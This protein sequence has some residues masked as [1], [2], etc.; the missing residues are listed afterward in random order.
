[1]A[2]KVLIVEDEV[3]VA[4]HLKADLED[5]GFE[6]TALCISSEECF[7]AVQQ[8]PPDVI[9]MDIHIKGELN[10]IEVTARL[11]QQTAIPII[12]LTSNTDAFTMHKALETRP[13]SFLS[14]PYNVKDLKAAIEIAFRSFNQNTP[15]TETSE[16]PA[17]VFVKRGEMYHRIQL[18]DILYISA[19]GSY[20]TVTTEKGDYMLSMN[21]QHFS[22]RIGMATIVRIHRSYSVNIAKVDRF[23]HFSV[24]INGKA[25]PVSKSYKEAVFKHLQRI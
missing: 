19:S 25:L 4:E 18:D 11:N 24:Y 13:Q 3:L 8:S 16:A 10:G 12:Y 22:H 5:M 7:A 6:V 9:L 20:C 1:M 15:D 14:K 17:S 2:V 23:D 21:L